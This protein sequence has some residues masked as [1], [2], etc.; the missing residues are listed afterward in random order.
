VAANAEQTRHE[1]GSSTRKAIASTYA[2]PPGELAQF[3]AKYE[4]S[5][6]HH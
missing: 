5:T 2:G 6:G 3:A 1:A 4:S